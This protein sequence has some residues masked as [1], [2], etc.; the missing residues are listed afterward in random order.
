MTRKS[1]DGWAGESSILV[2]AVG[3]GARSNYMVPA[4]TNQQVCTDGAGRKFTGSWM[5]PSASWRSDS[6]S[7]QYRWHTSSQTA[8]EEQQP[9]TAANTLLGHLVG[10]CLGS[11]FV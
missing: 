6:N 4:P 2:R 5:L 9:P 11:I 8:E 10:W 1:V 7:L 3:A